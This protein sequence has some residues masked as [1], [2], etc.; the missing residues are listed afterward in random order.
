MKGLNPAVI[1]P[2]ACAATPFAAF[3]N[4]AVPAPGVNVIDVGN[5]DND[6]TLE[7]PGIP[8]PAIPEAP[9]SD[10]KLGAPEIA[11]VVGND[12]NEGTVLVALLIKSVT[13]AGAAPPLRPPTEVAI[14]LTPP[15]VPDA[16]LEA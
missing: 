8:A 10:D 1:A 9:T 13:E 12:D 5:E 4:P 15:V 2:N 3:C 11:G 14:E 6:G 16:N 7:T